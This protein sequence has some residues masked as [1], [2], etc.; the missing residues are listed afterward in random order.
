[1]DARTH[2]HTHA[3]TAHVFPA[4]AMAMPGN[5]FNG[6][7]ARTGRPGGEISPHPAPHGSS[8]QLGWAG[9]GPGG[10]TWSQGHLPL[11]S[12][13]GEPDRRQRQ[14][15]CLLPVQVAG[16]R[17]A[18]RCVCSAHRPSGLTQVH[19][20]AARAAL[21]KSSRVFFNP[22]IFQILH[23]SSLSLILLLERG[24]GRVRTPR[25]LRD[26]S[27]RQLCNQQMPRTRQVA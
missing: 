20:P 24:S 2:T 19:A 9:G 10:P 13:A 6:A 22:D 8:G 23:I 18:R 26:L 11:G 4:M 12:V 3:H 16:G 25:S 27:P 14:L 21:L 5:G 1:M 17:L 15:L 7:A